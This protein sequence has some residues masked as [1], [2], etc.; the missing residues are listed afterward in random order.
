MNLIL[1]HIENRRRMAEV[2][3]ILNGVDRT[4]YVPGFTDKYICN[5]ERTPRGIRYFTT[6]Y[7]FVTNTLIRCTNK[8]HYL[9]DQYIE[10]PYETALAIANDILSDGW[11]FNIYTWN[12]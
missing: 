8:I 1:P 4:R 9:I 10:D 2:Y 6:E 7:R 12:T 3:A 11:K 5:V